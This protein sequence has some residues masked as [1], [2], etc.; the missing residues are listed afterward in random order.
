MTGKDVVVKQVGIA[1]YAD[2]LVSVG[3]PSP[4]AGLFAAVQ[5]NIKDGELDVASSDFDKLIGRPAT[6]LI[7][8]LTLIVKTI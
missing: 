8:A 3:L 4:I 1:E 2:Y 6:P 7:D 5:Q